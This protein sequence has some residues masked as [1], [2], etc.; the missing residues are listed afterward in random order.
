MKSK[1]NAGLRAAI[2]DIVVETMKES[3]GTYDNTGVPGQETGEGMHPVNFEHAQR[4]IFSTA[5]ELVKE[6]FITS[7]L[8]IYDAG[9]A[10]EGRKF[11]HKE[12][13]ALSEQLREELL[14]VVEKYTEIGFDRIV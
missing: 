14:K 7:M 3:W 4:E 10:P 5:L 6:E 9:F 1:A 12:L 11:A 13:V 8:D 2:Q